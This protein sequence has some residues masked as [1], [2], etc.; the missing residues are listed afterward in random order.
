MPM[1]FIHAA[2]NF[3]QIRNLTMA[4]CAQVSTNVYAKRILPGLK[5]PSQTAEANEGTKTDQ[6]SV[7][8]RTCLWIRLK[9]TT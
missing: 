4:G 3:M 6:A 7:E 2:A 8:C 5:F 9:H 1:L